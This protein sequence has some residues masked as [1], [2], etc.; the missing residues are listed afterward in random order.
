MWIVLCGVRVP[1]NKWPKKFLTLAARRFYGFDTSKLCAQIENYMETWIRTW[2]LI[3]EL[4]NKSVPPF[5][6]IIQ[7]ICS[8]YSNRLINIHC[9]ELKVQVDIFMEPLYV[10]EYIVETNSKNK[11]HQKPCCK[12]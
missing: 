7:T 3:D 11:R 5:D 8:I 4:E 10:N 2:K 1:R 12:L 6:W 9:N